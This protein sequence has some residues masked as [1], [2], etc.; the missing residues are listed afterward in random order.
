MCADGPAA[1]TFTHEKLDAIDVQVPS[2]PVIQNVVP[3]GV[4]MCRLFRTAHQANIFACTLNP[5]RCKLKCPVPVA[6][7]IGPVAVALWSGKKRFKQMLSTS[8]ER[9]KAVYP[10][11]KR[12]TF[13]LVS[14]RK[15]ESDKQAIS[16]RLVKQGFYVMNALPLKGGS[17]IA[18]LNEWVV[19]WM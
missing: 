10:R 8:H 11:N 7:G 9:A 18:R 3:T 1:E 2:V 14:R 13:A 12:M 17:Q 5:R 19:Y 6:A 15:P 16:A 4:R